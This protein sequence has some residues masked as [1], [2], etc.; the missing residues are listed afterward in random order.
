MKTHWVIM[1]AWNGTSSAALPAPLNRSAP[2]ADRESTS[3][4]NRTYEPTE[5]QLA[6][7]NVEE[8]YWRTTWQTRPYATADRGFEYY[9]PGYR[10]SFESAQRMRGAQWNDAER[11]LRTGWDS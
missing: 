3:N 11:E 9:R 4:S 6:D 2:M 5:G 7:W 8:T 10:Y 1:P